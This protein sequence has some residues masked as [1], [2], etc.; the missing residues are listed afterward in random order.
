MMELLR[1]I[2]IIWFDLLII[3]QC[4]VDYDIECSS[5]AS[6]GLKS[7]KILIYYYYYNLHLLICQ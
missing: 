1:L 3:L 2:D 5:E 6:D 7:M 4:T